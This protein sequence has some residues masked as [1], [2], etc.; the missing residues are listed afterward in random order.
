MSHYVYKIT[1]LVNGKFYIGKRKNSDP[2]SDT[3]MGSGKLIKKAIKKYGKNNFKKEIIS[4]FETNEEAA[5]LESKLVTK[6]VID[7]NMSY[8]L[9]EGGHGGF[10]HINNKPIEERINVIAHKTKLENGE[11]SC[12][13]TKGWT[14][15]SYE[16]V[17]KQALINLKSF[18]ENPGKVYWKNA[19]EEDRKKHSERLRGN[20]NPNYGK[21]SCIH[22]ETLK[23]KTFH[24]DKIPDGWILTEEYNEGKKNK[25]NPSYGKHWYTDKLKNYYLFSNDP[26]IEELGLIRGRLV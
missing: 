5:E 26:L 9:H 18:S 3:Y 24:K 1:N 21:V 20:K 11:I 13:G 25:N 7:S 19:T 22:L 4:I 14:E 8:N 6:D 2:E 15:E 23:K 10:H 12:G 16:K 17:R